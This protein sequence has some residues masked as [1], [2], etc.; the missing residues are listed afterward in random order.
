MSYLDQI[1]E[2]VKK[3]REQGFDESSIKNKLYSQ[4][5]DTD[6]IDMALS[7]EKVSYNLYF[8]VALII[9]VILTLTF[10][11]FKSSSESQNFNIT[12]S[13]FLKKSIDMEGYMK[14][15]NRRDIKDVPIWGKLQIVT[16]KKKEFNTQLINPSFD[17][18]YMRGP[19]GW[20]L[21][22]NIEYTNQ[23]CLNN[24]CLHI[25][26]YATD[27][28]ISL[29]N[30]QPINISVPSIPY[31]T[32]FNVYCKICGD[33][34]AYL[35]YIW[36]DAQDRELTRD[37]YVFSQTSEYVRIVVQSTPPSNATQLIIGI[38]VHTE[39]AHVYNLTELFIDGI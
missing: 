27:E 4:G 39:S 22:G 7:K 35:T 23:G 36:L 15:F 2:Y 24:Y 3:C 25:Y 5:I 37:Y 6:I 16:D 11:Y 19:F 18:M 8:A 9:V 30:S 32:A 26:G 38:R 34:A 31:V 10:L 14:I 20:N 33:Q 1:K 13:D 28:G 21:L 12:Y 29:I 17:R